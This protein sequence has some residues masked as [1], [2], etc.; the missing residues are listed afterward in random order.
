MHAC[1]TPGCPEVTT[2]A[3]R[4][5]D[6]RR[7]AERHR[8][9]A[10]SR[11]YDREHR[12]RFRPGVLAAHPTCQCGPDHE[13]H[14][15]TICP[16]WSTVADHWPQS[17][18]ELIELGLDSNDPQFGIGRCKPCHD[19]STATTPSQRGGWNQR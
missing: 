7:E 6:C 16:S 15:G 9:S 14:K 5:D 12:T 1:S 4:C 11:G 13:A 17:K 3:G 18:R 8:G 10:S 19:H 2:R